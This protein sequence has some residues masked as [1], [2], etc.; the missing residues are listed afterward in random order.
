MMSDGLQSLSEAWA[1]DGIDCK[2]ARFVNPVPVR[3]DAEPV[4]EFYLLHTDPHKPKHK[5]YMVDSLVYTPYGLIC[6]CNGETNIVP[7]GNISFVR[8]L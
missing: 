6:K 7:L 3:M 2:Y 5:K 8:S 1:M 4:Y